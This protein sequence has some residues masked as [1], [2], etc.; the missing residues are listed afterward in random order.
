MRRRRLPKPPPPPHDSAERTLAHRPVRSRYRTDPPNVT[1]R[2][3]VGIAS[4]PS[5]STIRS[6]SVGNVISG[7]PLAAHAAILSAPLASTN[8]KECAPSTPVGTGPT[9]LQ[10]AICRVIVANA[11]YDFRGASS[12]PVGIHMRP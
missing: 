3:C 5:C 1:F 4:L 8:R 12:P 7:V 9:Q 6:T 2:G 10:P 11:A